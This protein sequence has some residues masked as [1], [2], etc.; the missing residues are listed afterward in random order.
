MFTR[1]RKGARPDEDTLITLTGWLAVSPEQFVSGQAAERDDR[2]QTLTGTGT[3]LRADRTPT[4]AS[5]D[6]IESLLRAA[7][8]QLAE[9]EDGATA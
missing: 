8:D 3:Y 7:Y 2:R 5:A 1:L 4:P 9:R 6:A